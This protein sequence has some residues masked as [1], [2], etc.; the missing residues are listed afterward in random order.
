VIAR[1]A[2][3]DAL[4]KHLMGGILQCWLPLMVLR[5]KEKWQPE[6]ILNGPKDATSNDEPQKLWPLFWP[7]LLGA[8]VF[9]INIFVGRTLAF[10]LNATAASVLYLANRFVELPLGVFSAAMTTVILLGL[11]LM[12]AEKHWA[13]SADF[14]G[15]D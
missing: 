4:F 15:K 8:A 2:D 3:L 1:R 11:S 10:G 9:Q 12:I 5:S 7:A 13:T 14:T 6:W